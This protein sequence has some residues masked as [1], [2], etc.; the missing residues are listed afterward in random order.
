[1]DYHIKRQVLI[2]GSLAQLF[3]LVAHPDHLSQ[4]NPDIHVLSYAPS[5]I[6]GYDTDWEY[7]FGAMKLAGKS[8]VVAYEPPHTLNVETQGGIPSR[9]F[10]SFLGQGDGVLVAVELD[11][12]IPKPLAFMGS[13]LTKRNE[14]SVEMQLENLKMLAEATQRMGNG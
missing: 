14:K 1:M 7:Q 13:L 4:V 5:A 3:E 2:N 10:W 6:G 8:K 12:D 11:Y 9:W